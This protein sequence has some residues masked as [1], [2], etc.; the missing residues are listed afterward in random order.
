M[1]CL[2]SSCFTMECLLFIAT[3]CDFKTSNA[4]S[5]FFKIPLQEFEI[6]SVNQ[7]KGPRKKFDIVK[8]RDNGGSRYR[9]FFCLLLLTEL[10]GPKK[11]FEIEKVRDNGG[12]R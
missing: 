2:Q 3:F 7:S 10:K 9:T 5:S 4:R 12:S 6:T 11:K 1:E 8:V